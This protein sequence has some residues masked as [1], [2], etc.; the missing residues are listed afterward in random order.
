MY[1]FIQSPFCLFILIYSIYLIAL[2]FEP[3]LTCASLVLAGQVLYYLNHKLFDLSYFS[4]SFS[5]FLPRLA[6]EHDPTNYASHVAEITA[7][8]HHTQLIL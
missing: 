1:S 2:G 6:S 3:V 5:H 4:D 7:V 8:Y